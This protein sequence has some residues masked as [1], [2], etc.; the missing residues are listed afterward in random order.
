MSA[1]GNGTRDEV[2][3]PPARAARVGRVGG[4]EDRAA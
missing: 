4:E 1:H 3:R 2:M